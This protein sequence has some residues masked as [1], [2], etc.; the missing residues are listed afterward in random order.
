MDE[1]PI[2]GI[3][4]EQYRQVLSK[5]RAT[6]PAAAGV[7]EAAASLGLDA[8]KWKFAGRK[9]AARL[10]SAPPSEVEQ[11]EAAYA[12]QAA[13]EEEADAKRARRRAAREGKAP[14]EAKAAPLPPDVEPS[15]DLEAL[16]DL[17]VRLYRG[18]DKVKTY[19]RHGLDEAGFARLW[20]EWTAAFQHRKRDSVRY[21][22]IAM[23]A[24]SVTE[25][26]KLRRK[27]GPAMVSRVRA[28]RCSWC[29]AHKRTV[30]TRP[31]IAC[32][33]CGVLF[34]YDLRARTPAQAQLTDSGR[35]TLDNYLA[36]EP[37]PSNR[38]E[39]EAYDLAA[40]RWI[41]DVLIEATPWDYPARIGDRAYRDR[42][43]DEWLLPA[44]KTLRESDEYQSRYREM[45]IADR[46]LPTGNQSFM[47]VL[48]YFD[49][50]ERYVAV[51]VKLLG[52][53]G[54]FER[55]PD[56]MTAE[57]YRRSR[58]SVFVEGWVGSMNPAEAEKLI[59]HAG[60]HDEFIAL[61]AVATANA[62]CGKCG[63][64]LVLIQSATRVVCDE[65]GTFADATNV[66]SCQVCG[67]PMI[68]AEGRLPDECAH[69]GVRWE[70]V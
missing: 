62:G 40:Q 25:G 15:R 14:A 51:Q 42:Y 50:T 31:W 19:A 13:A 22:L 23:R 8:K 45:V 17:A 59:A 66:Y 7:A 54:L 63:S 49:M 39:R 27:K 6:D 26:E 12:A 57:L 30:H 10:A 61:P 29:G 9:W 35:E 65:C 69:C 48:R 38:A 43:L 33:A 47:T 41:H 3:T 2:F 4:L 64:T 46:A 11:R 1:E 16:I 28:R 20:E 68:A 67:G 36:T 55:H 21:G 18:E 32:D 5:A 56:K 24:S 60:M 52:D 58:I 53:A 70:S 44:E 34:D 37:K